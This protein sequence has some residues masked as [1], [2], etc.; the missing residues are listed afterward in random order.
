MNQKLSNLQAEW[1]VGGLHEQSSEK[2]IQLMDLSQGFK[3][4]TAEED[5]SMREALRVLFINGWK[6]GL[7]KLNA[8][9]DGGEVQGQILLELEPDAAGQIDLQK[10]LK[11]NGEVKVTGKL[12]TVDQQDMLVKLGMAVK[13]AEGL[14][15]N[16]S[17]AK[18]KLKINGKEDEAANLQAALQKEQVLLN[19]FFSGN[20]QKNEGSLSSL[21]QVE[22]EIVSPEASAAAPAAA[23]AK[24]AD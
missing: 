13:T 15:S 5:K 19:A 4:M 23:P 14:Q 10:N 2:L 21:P 18:G 8:Q 22:E 1:I 6:V 11:L 9:A 16:V 3:N 7:S 17:M 24:A 20:V 12:L